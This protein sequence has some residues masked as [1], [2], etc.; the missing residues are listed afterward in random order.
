MLYSIRRIATGE[1]ATGYRRP[2]MRN[3]SRRW[4]HTAVGILFVICTALAVSEQKTPWKIAGELEEA[5]SCDAACPC[6]W[7]SKPTKM[8][9]GG[10][11]NLFLKKRQLRGKR[12]A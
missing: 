3:L 9:C 5:C 1:T 11:G 12:A 2:I 7:G 4:F 6:W 10:G 8:T